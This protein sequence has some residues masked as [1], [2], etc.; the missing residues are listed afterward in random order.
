MIGGHARRCA[1]ADVFDAVGEIANIAAGNLRG[2]LAPEC[3][4]GLPEVCLLKARHEPS[5]PVLASAALLMLEQPL[6]VKLCGE[7]V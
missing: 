7:I 2:L 3:L 5:Q 1:A 6:L 4:L